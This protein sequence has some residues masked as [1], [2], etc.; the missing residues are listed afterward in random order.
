MRVL[1]I[2][3]DGFVGSN[4]LA[5][6]GA[7]HEVF[8]ANRRPKAAKKDVSIDLSSKETIGKALAAVRPDVV[9]NCAGIVDNSA[10]AEQ[11]PIFTSNLLVAIKESGLDIKK[12]IIS[13]SAAEYGVVDKSNIPVKET[14]PLNANNGYG[15]SKLKETTLALEFGKNSKIQIVIARIFNPIGVGMH[16]RFMIPRIISQVNEFK[17]GQREALE[18]SRLDSKRDYVNIKDVA[19]AVKAIAEGEAKHSVYNIGSGKSTSNEELVRAIISVSGLPKAP[20]IKET[21]ETEE[22]LVAIQADIS[23]I[24]SDLGWEPMH[25]FQETVEEIIHDAYK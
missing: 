18:V 6:F 8:G 13:G 25:T 24:K 20:H 21:S 15:L 10:A 5:A 17:N 1:V 2:G 16:E 11:N 14:A 3:S 12:V 7:E 9:I 4:V 23:L 19:Q 22:P